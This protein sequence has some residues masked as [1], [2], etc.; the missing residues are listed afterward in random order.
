M[1]ELWLI[2]CHLL[3]FHCLGPYS[4][5]KA[6]SRETRYPRCV[7]TSYVVNKECVFVTTPGI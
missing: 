1:V 4:C 7:S 5:S 6:F 3:L 2:T